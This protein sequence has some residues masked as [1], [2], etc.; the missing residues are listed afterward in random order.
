[1]I[2]Y[3]PR[4][5]AKVS[6]QAQF[7]AN[8]GLIR[9]DVQHAAASPATENA[10]LSPRTVE[11]IAPLAANVP[12]RVQTIPPMPKRTVQPHVRRVLVRP[13][14]VNYP[15]QPAQPASANSHEQMQGFGPAIDQSQ[16]NSSVPIPPTG[17]IRPVGAWTTQ[18]PPPNPALSAQAEMPVSNS[19]SPLHLQSAPTHG[20]AL[21]SV[22]PSDIPAFRAEVQAQIPQTPQRFM[23]NSPMPAWLGQLSTPQ[24]AQSIEHTMP[25]QGRGSPLPNVPVGQLPV[26]V[27]KG[28]PPLIEAHEQ[29]AQ[30][31]NDSESYLATSVAAERW[32][33]SWRN[34][35]RSE[36]GPATTASRGQSMVQEPLMAMQNS[37]VRMRA[38]VVPKKLQE[39]QVNLRF[40]ITLLLMIC[41]I[42]GLATFI[43]ATF[44]TV[45]DSANQGVQQSVTQPPNLSISGT[46]TATI[47]Q[48]QF[49]HLHGDNFAAAASISFLLDGTVPIKGADGRPLSVLSSEQGSFDVVVHVT[50]I[51]PTGPH[52]L[53]AHDSKHN[54]NAYL[55][56]DIS[57]AGPAAAT[58][59]ESAL[60]ANRLKFQAVMEQGI[61]KEQCSYHSNSPVVVSTAAEGYHQCK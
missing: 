37:L 17:L 25:Q 41:I 59:R 57:L 9:R 54:Q 58:S 56:I 34:R 7:C 32:R 31:D 2:Y 16:N 27:V 26:G 50:S 30:G 22:P 20:Q 36:A 52:V 61:P 39:S 29:F 49:L 53:Q 4:C 48:G 47:A 19:A 1:M 33:T 46:P 60:S 11:G 43:A 13:N 44:Q 8:C 12:E 6:E 40:W 5:S 18:A 14:S 24:P 15:T 10:A 35:Q 55:N 38:I 51:W 23:P 28:R 3:C 42:V 21:P 45:P